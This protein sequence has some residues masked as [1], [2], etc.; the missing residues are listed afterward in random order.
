MVFEAATFAFFC[1][2]VLVLAGLD[3][4]VDEAVRDLAGVFVV[5]DLTVVF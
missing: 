3:L 4:V 1:V 2:V 5:D